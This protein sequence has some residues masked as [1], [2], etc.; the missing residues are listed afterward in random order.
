MYFQFFLLPVYKCCIYKTEYKIIYRFYTK[1]T[2]ISPIK[3]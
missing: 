2:I 1:V 3:I